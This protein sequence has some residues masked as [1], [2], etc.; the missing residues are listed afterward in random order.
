MAALA[1]LPEGRA[2]TEQAIDLRLDLRSPLL[3]LGPARAGA[4]ALAGSGGDGRE[5]RRRAAAGARLHLPDQLPLSEGRA[6]PRH[7]VRRALPAH[8]RRGRRRGP[9]GARARL[10]GL[11]LSRSGPLS[12]RALDPARERG[13]PRDGAGRHA[14]RPDRRLLRHLERLARLHPG[15]PRRVR[16]RRHVARPGAARG[17]GERARLHP[18]HRADHGRARLAAARPARAGAPRAAAEPRRL[19]REEPRR[20]AA[21]SVLAA[22]A[23]A[24]AARAGGGGDA[25]PGGRRHP[26]RGAGRARLPRAL[27]REP[28]RGPGRRAAARPRA[29]RGAAARSTWRSGTRSAGTR[30]G[31]C[32]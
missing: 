24:R 21:D 10:P 23:H 6:R 13:G 28:G 25:A 31:R 22:R 2:A 27:D 8:R 4:D 15:R 26:H 5:A 19:P 32:A 12:P 7:R 1:R 20:V 3:Q 16:R 9:A 14:G 18:D 30:R 11:Q 29:H 17:R